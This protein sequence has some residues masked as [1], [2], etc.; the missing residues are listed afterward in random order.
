MFRTVT[1]IHPRWIDRRCIIIAL[2]IIALRC[3]IIALRYNCVD[4]HYNC[5]NLPA[6]CF[7]PPPSLQMPH[8]LA[9]AFT[10]LPVFT[11]ASSLSALRKRQC[12]QLSTH[13]CSFTSYYTVLTRTRG[14]IF[15][16]GTACKSSLFVCLWSSSLSV[17][18][19]RLDGSVIHV[20]R[21][22][23]HAHGKYLP[24]MCSLL[25]CHV[26]VGQQ[27]RLIIC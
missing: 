25:S 5:G 17:T 11:H 23:S 3:I 21:Q 7:N 27:Q 18:W 6:K 24:V 13:R 26:F 2:Y 20:S 12:V 15:S 16:W 10:S 22:A 19:V 8:P 4:L 9:D 14:T 1:V